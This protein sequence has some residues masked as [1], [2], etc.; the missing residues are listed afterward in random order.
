MNFLLK[1]FFRKY[2]SP[3]K[4]AAF[5][6][7]VAAD[8]A[9][10]VFLDDHFRAMVRFKQQTEGE[11][12]RI[13]NELVVTGL[14]LLTLLI[15]DGY[16]AIIPER[17]EFWRGVREETPLQFTGWLSEVGVAAEFTRIWGKLIQLRLEEYRAGQVQTRYAWVEE[18]FQDRD[19]ETLGDAAVRI[20]TLVIGSLLRLTRGAAKPGD[21]LRKHLRAWLCALD[22]KLASHIGW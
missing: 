16:T 8:S 6:V 12:N 5:L 15:D 4:E 20:E 2:I 7:K 17:K 14:V 13:F 18:L 11:Q 10:Q 1:K 21:L 9:Y 3:K 22:R 19:D